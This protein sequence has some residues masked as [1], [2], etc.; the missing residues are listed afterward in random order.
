MKEASDF[1][2]KR[3]ISYT[4]DIKQKKSLKLNKTFLKNTLRNVMSSNKSITRKYNKHYPKKKTVTLRKHHGKYQKTKKVHQK[5][6][7]AKQRPSGEN[8]TKL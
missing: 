2:K 3:D 1:V 5:L 7:T 8:D 4:E 6:N